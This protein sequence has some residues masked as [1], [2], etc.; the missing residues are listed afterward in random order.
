MWVYFAMQVGTFATM[1]ECKRAAAAAQTV[2]PP[3]IAL[4]PHGYICVQSK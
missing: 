1:D 3:K 2:V 4:P